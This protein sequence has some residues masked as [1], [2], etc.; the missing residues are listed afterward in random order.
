[1][2]RTESNPLYQVAE[3]M[4]DEKSLATSAIVAFWGIKNASAENEA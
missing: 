3:R 1:M 4:G 2:I